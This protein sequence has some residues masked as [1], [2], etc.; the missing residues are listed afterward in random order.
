MKMLNIGFHSYI[1]ENKIVAIVSAD[2]SPIR[3]NI[4]EAKEKGMLINA[5][6][7]RPNLSVIVT[8][9]NYLVLSSIDKKTLRKRVEENEYSR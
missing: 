5:C 6:Y 9:S 7:G 3:R 4:N 8:V 2:S 1:P